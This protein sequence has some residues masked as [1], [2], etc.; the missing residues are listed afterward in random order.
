MFL[1]TCGECPR[2]RSSLTRST[3]TNPLPEPCW[4]IW[5]GQMKSTVMGC[6][7]QRKFSRWTRWCLIIT[8]S[9]RSRPCW[10]LV[11][12][13]EAHLQADLIKQ[14]GVGGEFLTKK[15][16]LK[17]TRQE[18]VPMWPPHGKDLMELIHAEAREILE[19]HTPPPLPDGAE[20]AFRKF[21]KKP[22]KHW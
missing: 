13:D 2:N 3:D 21:W 20:G 8:S 22:I 4:P 15:E 6:W 5:P 11:N 7:A 1:P 18:Y 17:Y 10:R 16:T 19:N 12:L 14:V 9:T